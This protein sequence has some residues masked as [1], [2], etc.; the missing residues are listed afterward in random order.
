MALNACFPVLRLV[1]S[2]TKQIIRAATI[3]GPGPVAFTKVVKIIRPA[4]AAEINCK[5]KVAK[6]KYPA[7]FAFSSLNDRGGAAPGANKLN[8]IL[9]FKNLEKIK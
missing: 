1:V 6:T 7:I 2:I 4:V 5:K 9:S 3:A 8:I